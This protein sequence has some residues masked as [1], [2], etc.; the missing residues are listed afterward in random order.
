MKSHK[1]LYII[2]IQYQQFGNLNKQTLYRGKD[3]MKNF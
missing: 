3:C 2:Y 1:M